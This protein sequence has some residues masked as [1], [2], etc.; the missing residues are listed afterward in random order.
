MSVVEFLLALREST[1]EQLSPRRLYLARADYGTGSGFLGL[2][3]VSE[4]TICLGGM[5]VC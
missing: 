2:R 1:M 4:P 3:V 5:A